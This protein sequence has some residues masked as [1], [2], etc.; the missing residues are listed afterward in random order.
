MHIRYCRLQCGFKT[1]TVSYG[2]AVLLFSLY[3][4]KNKKWFIIWKNCYCRLQWGFKITV[5]SCSGDS[6]SPLKAIARILNPRC[7]LLHGIREKYDT[8][9]KQKSNP[10]TSKYEPLIEKIHEK[11]WSEKV[12]HNCP[13]KEWCYKDIF[14]FAAPAWDLQRKKLFKFN[15]THIS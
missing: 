3:F 7:I 4:R 10:L 9:T 14:Y 6:Q 15:K 13:F 2:W 1:A 12:L 11:N 5:V 8:N